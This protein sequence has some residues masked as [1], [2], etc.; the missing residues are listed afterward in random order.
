[1]ATQGIEKVIPAVGWLK[2]YSSND[3]PG[4]LTAGI[5]TAILLVPQAMAYSILAGLPPEVGLYASILPPILYAFFGSSRTLA[6]GPVAVAS[7]MVAAALGTIAIPGSADYIYAALVLSALIGL[8]LLIMGIAKLGFL[9]NFLSHPVMSG[10]TSA[11]AIVIAFSQLKHLLGIEI[12]RGSRIDQSLS[13]IFNHVSDIN[14][15]T[16][17]ISGISLILLYSLRQYLSPLLIRFG[18]S[19][20]IAKTLVK[21]G[22]MF[23][24]LLMTLLSAKM[25]WNETNGLVVVGSIPA[26]LPPLTVPSFDFTLW[27]EL[28]VSAA[29]IALVSF[30][31]SVAIARVLASKRRQKIDVNQELVGL[32]VANI[33]AAFTGGSPVCGGFSRSV[34]NFDAGAN[35]Q[36][37]AII[38]AALIALSVL[39]FTPLFYYLP[40]AVLAAIIIIAVL[41]LVDLKALKVNWTYSKSDAAAWLVT[42]AVVMAEGIELGII[43]GIVVSLIL[44]LWRSSKPHIAIVGRVGSSEHFRN[45]KRHTVRTCAHVL[46]MRVDESLFFANTRYFENYVLSAIVDQPEVKHVVFICSAINAI[47]G[48]ALESLETLISDLKNAGVTFHLAEVK[49]PVMDRLERTHFLEHLKP[50]KVYL[51]THDAFKDL[52]CA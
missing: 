1:M 28:A 22:P 27:R 20:K 46:A 5:I 18:L 33:G 19:E 42:F 12:P 36:L 47:D 39:F 32:G 30:V 11:A 44:F 4:D 29:L 37:A 35:T 9:A 40:Q 3:L 25:L 17:I 21:A 15:L 52:D 41:G 49:G 51:S 7:L 45:I 14:G 26:G 13:Y 34:V 43:A 48:S 38:T 24:V 6:V 16:V 23:V 50:G 31:E 8:F 10:F 2:S